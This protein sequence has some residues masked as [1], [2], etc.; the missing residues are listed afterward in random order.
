MPLQ[1]LQ[2]FEWDGTQRELAVWWTLR[3]D[4]RIAQCRLLSHAFGWEL[5]L[6]VD[7]DMRHTATCRSQ[8][9]VLD[10]HEGWFKRLEASGWV[11]P[12]DSQPTD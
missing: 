9:D 7:G 8:E 1:V 12:H 6:E 4:S 10:T 2:R 11:A 3:K 5:R